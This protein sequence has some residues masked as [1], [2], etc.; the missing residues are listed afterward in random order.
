MSEDQTD[1]IAEAMD[2]LAGEPAAII[3]QPHVRYLLRDGL[4]EQWTVAWVKLSTA[5]KPHIKELRGA[6]L[7]VWLFISLS[8]NKSG[9]AFPG[10]R[11]IADETGYS[12]QGVLNAIATLEEKGYLKV[13][14]GERRF[15]LYEPEFAAIGQTNE[16]SGSVNSVD[17]TF[18]AD[19]STFSP[20]E[21]TSLDSNKINKN[22]QEKRDSD[23]VIFAAL[24]ELT[25]GGLNSNTPKFVDAWLEK[26][27]QEWI[28]RAVGIA[29]EKR[30]RS[31]KYV[32]EILISWE[33]NGYP[34]TREERV[35]ER[36]KKNSG[37]EPVV[38]SLD[39]LTRLRAQAAEMMGGN[40]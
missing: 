34:K 1:Y 28:L 9:I 10:I 37:F 29:K 18:P 26:H 20:D 8:I 31:I 6:P 12:H 3:E 4:D 38:L 2:L 39:E 19:E 23:S 25:G 35:R 27:T 11:T 21:S 15:N 22:K 36:K 32:D 24:S 30:A 33:A 17:S 7:A 13:R 16:P 5:F 14:R 40:K